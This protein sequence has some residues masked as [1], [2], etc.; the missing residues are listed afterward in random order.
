PPG[1]LHRSLPRPAR[2]VDRSGDALQAPLVLRRLLAR[3]RAEPDAPADLR[4]RLAH[5]GG[6]RQASLAA[7]GG[8]E[9]RP[10]EAPARARSVRAPRRL[11]GRALPSSEP[12]DGR[13]RAGTLPPG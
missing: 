11:A 4:H 3:R 5:A 13:A 7:R 6:A 2:G 9:A 12:L 1:R 8:E 10:S